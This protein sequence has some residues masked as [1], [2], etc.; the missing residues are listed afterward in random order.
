[1]SENT[2]PQQVNETVPQ[3]KPITG[4][5]SRP[6]IA[7]LQVR[8]TIRTSLD[9]TNY[10]SAISVAESR[11]FP[12]RSYLY[13]IYNNV[14]LDGHLTGVLT[15][16]IAQVLNKE[17]F[18]V[19]AN[20][21]R[22]PEMDTIIR[23]LPFRKVVRLVIESLY[24][25]I[26]GME[27]VPGKQMDVRSIPRKH[28]K[29]KT[30]QIV[31]EQNQITGGID[32]TTLDN[33]WIVGD[34][35][36]LGILLNCSLYVIYKRNAIGDWAQFIEIFGMPSRVG[37][38]DPQDESTRTTLLSLFNTA[39]A[40]TDLVV[41]RTAEIKIEDGK[42]ANANGD[43][44]LQFI[45][46]MDQEISIL[47]LGNTETTTNGKTGS[48]AKSKVHS[49]QQN[50]I[51]KADIAYV[52]ATLNDPHFYQVLQSY[53]IPITPGGRFAFD[54]DI[55]MAALR[56]R[57]EIDQIASQMGTPIPL[58]YINDTYGIPKPEDGEEIIGAHPEPD[59][60]EAQQQPAQKEKTPPAAGKVTPTDLSDDPKPVMVSLSNHD[61]DR[62]I[63]G[64]ADKLKDTNF[65]D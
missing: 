50:E 60:D 53:N 26:S 46:Q 43:L 62:I 3:D 64:L 47:V 4:G 29:T 49:Q 51:V 59:G 16:R 10:K 1:M 22:V 63:N 55:D 17:I 5:Q 39:G 57:I 61:Y 6:V 38:Y 14:L 56:E 28:I 65:F 48:Q 23:S 32:Y 33:V 7:T 24:W 18:W 9:I 31:P 27:F 20:G 44:Q 35:E 52:E 58:S 45:N 15:K 8:Q 25:G 34:D 40:N 12:N 2:Q 42:T 36:D 19:D 37:Y 11:Y 13:D 21:E 41:P 30:Q 54:K